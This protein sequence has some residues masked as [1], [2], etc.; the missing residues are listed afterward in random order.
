MFRV[1]IAIGTAYGLGHP[2]L[3][4]YRPAALDKPLHGF[5]FD[6]NTAVSQCEHAVKSFDGARIMYYLGKAGGQMEAQLHR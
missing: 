4:G 3:D 1:L 2:A 5:Y 6:V